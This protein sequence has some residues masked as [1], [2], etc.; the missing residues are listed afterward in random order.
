MRAGKLTHRLVYEEP[1]ETA[2]S[3]GQLVATWSTVGSLWG[4]V[5]TPNGREALIAQ[6]LRDHVSHVVTVRAQTYPIKPTGRIRDLDALPGTSGVYAIVSAT[7][8]LGDRRSLKLYTS[9]VV[10]PTSTNA[11]NL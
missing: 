8:E 11:S 4:E 3:Y 2:D 7:D 10:T 1:T 6:T 5:R 9:E